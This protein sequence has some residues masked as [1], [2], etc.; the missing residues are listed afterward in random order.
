MNEILD[1]ISLIAKEKGKSMESFISDANLKSLSKLPNSGLV[2]KVVYPYNLTPILEK[3]N[4]IYVPDL[5]DKFML[6][7][8]YI[9]TKTKKPTEVS[10]RMEEYH[11][12][13]ELGIPSPPIGWYMS[14]KFDGQ[15]ALWDG[16]KFVTRGSPSGYPRVYPYVPKWFIALMPP[17]I[18]LDGE[19]YIKR[20]FFQEIG[21]LKSKLKPESDRKKNDNTQME[22]D[23][24]WNL[25]KYQVFDLPTQDPFEKRQKILEK[26]ITE[27]ILLWDKIELPPYLKKGECPL[28]LT[29]QHLITSEEL[30]DTFYNE[31]VSQDAEGLMIRAPKIPYIPKRTRFML[32][33]KPEEDAECTILGYKPGEGK[34]KN[35]LGSFLCQNGDK[36]F[37]VGGMTDQIRKDYLKTH[38]IGT[39]ITYKYTFTTDGGIPR[40]PRYKG[41]PGDR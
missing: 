18:A 27:R 31:I 4:D 33:L 28:I 2:G 36:Q 17:G 25:I 19:F 15:R 10:K 21:F 32:K 9:D 13:T 40:H 29:K 20:N 11:F 6:G 22:L 39:L 35:L 7:F 30:V 16:A 12:I 8:S 34:Y 14:E 37:Y 5:A 41:I 24:K 38:P 23:K 3:N 26:I 1:C